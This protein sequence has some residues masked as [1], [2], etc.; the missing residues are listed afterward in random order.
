MNEPGRQ[1][2]TIIK[3][4]IIH[5]SISDQLCFHTVR[6]KHHFCLN[7]I[8]WKLFWTRMQ[9]FLIAKMLERGLH[10]AAHVCERSPD[11]AQCLKLCTLTAVWTPM[12]TANTYKHICAHLLGS[13]GCCQLRKA[14]LIYFLKLTMGK[15]WKWRFCNSLQR[16]LTSYLNV[17]Y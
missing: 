10:M 3:L 8:H 1:S 7:H 14:A 16:L 15:K 5:N 9:D 12:Q 11:A 13:G 17:N 6:R 4:Q 2:D